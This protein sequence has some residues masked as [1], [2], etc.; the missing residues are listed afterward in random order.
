M[1]GGGIQLAQKKQILILKTIREARAMAADA[2]QAYLAS[3][4]KHGERIIDDAEA[5]EGTLQVSIA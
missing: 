3:V 1:S 4:R 2:I 5:F